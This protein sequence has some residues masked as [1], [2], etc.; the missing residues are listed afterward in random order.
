[1]PGQLLQRPV[2]ERFLVGLE[3]DQV[4]RRQLFQALRQRPGE[5]AGVF[6][7]DDD[8]EQLLLE[9]EVLFQLD[10]ERRAAEEVGQDQ[11]KE[12]MPIH[13]PHPRR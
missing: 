1:M 10:D 5:G 3:G 12:A 13:G 4:V 9:R 6:A 11:A 2:I 7:Q 8:I